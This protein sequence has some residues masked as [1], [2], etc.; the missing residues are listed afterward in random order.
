MLSSIG[1]VKDMASNS[2]LCVYANMLNYIHQSSTTT[3]LK[4]V[5]LMEAYFVT[6]M[7]DNFDQNTRFK[8]HISLVH[9]ILLVLHR[10]Y[11][12]YCMLLSFVLR[13]LQF[14]T[15]FQIPK[16]IVHQFVGFYL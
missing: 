8:V 3:D 6:S 5:S 15:D 14:N 7:C 16:L 11:K 4:S 1:Y 2:G 12:S 9:A 13:S 10:T